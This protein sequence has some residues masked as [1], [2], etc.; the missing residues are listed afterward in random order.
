[1][2]L[3]KLRTR[4]DAVINALESMLAFF[5]WS[6]M[7]FAFLSIS[8]IIGDFL[9]RLK[10]YLLLSPQK[11][12][13]YW[14]YTKDKFFSSA[15]VSCSSAKVH[16]CRGPDSP[17][18]FLCIFSAFSY[19]GR[20]GDYVWRYLAELDSSGLDIAYI[21]ASPLMNSDIERLSSF[22][23]FVVEKPNQCQDFSSW[24]IGLELSNN[25]EGY[26]SVLLTNDSVFGP[27]FDLC[28]IIDTMRE[29]G[30]ALW[31]LTESSELRQ[32]LQSYFV[33]AER[34]VLDSSAWKDFWKDIRWKNSRRW[35][36]MKYEIGFSQAMANAGFQ[37]YAWVSTEKVLRIPGILSGC[38][39]IVLACALPLIEY[40]DFPFLKRSL[41]SKE[42]RSFLYL[43]SDPRMAKNYWSSLSKWRDSLMQVTDYPLE[44]IE[45]EV[46]RMPSGKFPDRDGCS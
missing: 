10:R 35:I 28:K 31:G 42:F 9:Y 36:C 23:R 26:I 24:R 19:D 4:G 40:F 1:M 33:W 16:Y 44:L 12:S 32:H 30:A 27:F 13:D 34:N 38:P 15:C 22:C 2:Y 18:K 37:F 41:F 45:T 3:I 17:K 7:S 11:L 20:I 5:E 8:C 6:M 25:A 14:E 39:N 21:S 29:R 43:Y 46:S